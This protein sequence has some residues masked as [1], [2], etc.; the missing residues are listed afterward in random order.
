MDERAA[1]TNLYF[2][3]HA[4]AVYTPDEWGRPLSARGLQDKEKL[5]VLLRA[6]QI[7][8]IISSPY[9]RAIETVQGIANDY[10]KK[11]ELIDAFKE[12]TLAEKPVVDFQ[13]AMTKVWT[14]WDFSWQGGE[15][16]NMAQQ[17]GVRATINLLEKYSG[18]NIVIGT[19]GN[20]MVLIMNYF[21]ASFDYNFWKAL[22]MPDVYELAFD[23]TKLVK[24]SHIV[25]GEDK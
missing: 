19:H 3:R 20:I 14:N 4:H 1:A 6:K 8:H 24:V 17:R 10:E 15:S 7:D 9:Q 25:E 16:N 12:R 11:I 22:M 2:V 18:K 13:A 23:G 5:T 21:D